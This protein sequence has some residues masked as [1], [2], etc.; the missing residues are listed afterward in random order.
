MHEQHFA[1]LNL[2]AIDQS[3][4]GGAVRGQERCAFCIVE[5]RG[6]RHQL[7]RRNDGLI[8]ISAV[9]HLHDNPVAHHDAGNAVGNLGHLPGRFHSGRE[10]QLGLELIFAGRHQYIGKID[11]GGMHGDAH[12]PL[13]QRRGSKG[14][15]A[16]TLGRAEFA[17]NDGLR[18]QAALA[19]RRCKASRISGSRSLP[20]YISVLSTKMVGEPNPPRAITSSVLAL[21]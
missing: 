15:Q 18:H 16:Q 8:G 6:Q 2:A 9:A 10:G 14:F 11:P 19:F 1:R 20:K 5:V 7:R 12:L 17:A 21:S 4:M 3:M 13:R